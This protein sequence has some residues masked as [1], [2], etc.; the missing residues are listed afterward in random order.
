M[1]SLSVIESISERISKHAVITSKNDKNPDAYRY[2]SAVFRFSVMDAWYA[3]HVA[4]R[5]QST[6]QTLICDVAASQ[7]HMIDTVA[8]WLCDFSGKATVIGDTS[9]DLHVSLLLSASHS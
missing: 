3:I 8:P 2:E 4:Y 9:D 1:I 6:M 5:E 7:P